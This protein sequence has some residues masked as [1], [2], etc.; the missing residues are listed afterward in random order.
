M[1]R[2]AKKAKRAKRPRVFAFFA[3]FAFFASSSPFA[4]RPDFKNVS[5]HQVP[6]QQSSSLMTRHNDMGKAEFNKGFKEW[7][8]RIIKLESPS[9][10]II[11]YNIGLF[12][13]ENGFS[14]YLCGAM[15]YSVR[16]GDWATEEAFTPKERYFSFPSEFARRIDW[17]QAQK[18]TIDA[19]RAFLADNPNSFLAK[20]K[21]VTVGFDEGDL[22]RI[23]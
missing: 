3:L 21:A 1:Q 15:K 9:A 8:G 20:A 18:A 13:T 10:K 4:F 16:N 23:K 5:R 12:E 14:A 7:L 17:K 6:R 19:V 11:A 22:V 2:E